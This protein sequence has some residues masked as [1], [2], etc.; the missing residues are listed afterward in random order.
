MRRTTHS[1][2]SCVFMS[3]SI[4]QNTYTG[5]SFS[6]KNRAARCLWKIVYLLLFRFTPRP[7]HAWRAFI[8]RCLGAK[9]GKRCHIYPTARIWAPWNLYFDDEVGIGEYVTLYNQAP[10]TLGKRVVISQGTHLCTGT[11]DYTKPG[12][13]LIAHPITVG[14]NSWI[15]AESFVHPRVS[16]GEGCVVGA[17]S[18][19]TKNLPPWYIC[20]GNPCTPIKPRKRHE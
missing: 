5:P 10:I 8:L 19:V 9:L 12:F 11:H 3:R 14:A 17:R 20:A 16:I 18:V 13:P 15:A 4:N 7:F 1:N 2:H 6:L